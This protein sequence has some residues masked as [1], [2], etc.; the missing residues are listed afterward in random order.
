MKKHKI[1]VYG[2]CKNEEKFVDRFMDCLEE[3]KD[4]VYILDTGSTDNTVEKFK[5]RGAHIKSKKYQKFEFDKARNDSLKLVPEKYDICIC[6]DMDDC[7]EPGFIDE[8]N[9]N[10]KDDTTQLRYQYYYRLDDL[11][12]PLTKFF[13]GKIHKRDC[14]RWK[15]PIHEVLEYIGDNE[16]AFDAPNIIFKHRTDFEKSREFYLDLL[17]EYVENNPNDTRNTY[18]LAREYKNLREWEKCIKISHSYLKI[19]N[20]NYK[21]ERGQLM[22]FMAKSYCKLEYYEEAELWGLKALEEV[23]ECRTPY[24]E[25]M[26]IYYEQKKYEK[27]LYY[28]LESL[29]ITK[30]NRHM[31][32]DI[33]CWDGTIY[34]YISLCYYYLED[35][36]KA[37]EYIDIDIKQNPHIQRLKD[38]RELFIKKRDKK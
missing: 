3:I 20:A 36:D 14:Y 5:A 16:I 29:K 37:I 33:N 25:L 18:L 32:E 8:I 13:C 15:Y 10:W 35:Y 22:S 6:L 26:L 28:G 23:S 27:A 17:E 31:T 24:V 1:C 4:H 19:K 9:N 12:E 2:I 21:E 7:I 11:D 30:R 34:D 38:N